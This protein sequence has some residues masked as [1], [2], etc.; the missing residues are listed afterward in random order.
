M[1]V[2]SKNLEANLKW[3]NFIILKIWCS[4]HYLYIL[5]EGWLSK[6]LIALKYKP[7]QCLITFTSQCYPAVQ[8]SSSTR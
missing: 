5:D 4:V 2:E 3:K 6:D 8:N 1:D 7:F